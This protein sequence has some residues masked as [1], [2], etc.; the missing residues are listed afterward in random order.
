MQVPRGLGE[1]SVRVTD[2]SR[3][4]IS[5]GSGVGLGEMSAVQVTGGLGEMLAVQVTGGLG[6]KSVR[7]AGWVSVRCQ[8]CR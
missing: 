6:G 8:Q 5:A 7:V 3:W 1:K 4:E 2:G